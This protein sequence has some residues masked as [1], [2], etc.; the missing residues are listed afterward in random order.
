MWSEWNSLR[1]YI[2]FISYNANTPGRTNSSQIIQHQS[3]RHLKHVQKLF[4]KYYF[5][6]VVKTSSKSRFYV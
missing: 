3:E 2:I 4:Y 1:E 5:F 6:F